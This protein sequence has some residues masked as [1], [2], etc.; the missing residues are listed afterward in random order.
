MDKL[1][2]RPFEYFVSGIGFILVL[3]GLLGQ[4]WKNLTQEELWAISI[5]GGISLISGLIVAIK[6]A[7][8]TMR[9]NLEKIN[10]KK[11]VMTEKT[12]R[13]ELVQNNNGEENLSD[14]ETF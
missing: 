2:N 9:T 6:K 3:I 12:K 8:Y 14:L 7:D 4:P 10:Y 13:L 5:F 1:A 11:F